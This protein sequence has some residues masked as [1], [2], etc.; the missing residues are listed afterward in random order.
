MIETFINSLSKFPGPVLKRCCEFLRKLI[1]NNCEIHDLMTKNENLPNKVIKA[2]RTYCMRSST[3]YASDYLSKPS[4][5]QVVQK[6]KSSLQDEIVYFQKVKENEIEDARDGLFSE[7]DDSLP[8]NF[9]R[10]KAVEFYDRTTKKWIKGV[11]DNV[12]ENMV[13]VRVVGNTNAQY[14]EWFDDDFPYIRSEAEE[15]E[16]QEEE[17]EVKEEEE[18]EEMIH[19]DR[20]PEVEVEDDSNTNDCTTNELSLQPNTSPSVNSIDENYEE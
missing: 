13:K 18:E 9:K 17:A 10:E 7:S 16:D 1:K 20:S 5:F 4:N 15:P 3:S 19:E 6:L 11:V 8:M 2:L 14:F 12:Y